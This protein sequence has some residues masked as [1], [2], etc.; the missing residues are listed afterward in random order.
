MNHWADLKLPARQHGQQEA[1]RRYISSLNAMGKP[2]FWLPAHV[3]KSGA[4]QLL[5]DLAEPLTK[6]TALQCQC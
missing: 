1:M 4:V 6:Q 5:E 3:R 2:L